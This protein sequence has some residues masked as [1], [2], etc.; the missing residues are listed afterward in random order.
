MNLERI[1]RRAWQAQPPDEHRNTVNLWL[2]V[3]ETHLGEWVVDSVQFSAGGAQSRIAGFR[4]RSRHEAESAFEQARLKHVLAGWVPANQ[5]DPIALA[6]V[7]GSPD[8]SIDHQLRLGPPNVAQVSSSQLRRLRDTPGQLALV[9]KLNGERLLVV[10]GSGVTV[11]GYGDSNTTDFDTLRRAA[12]RSLLDSL[13][14]AEPGDPHL[15]FDALW[16]GG[17]LTLLDLISHDGDL[18]PRPFAMRRA[19]LSQV[20]SEQF[21][22]D[23]G[24]IVWS[25][26]SDGALLADGSAS[27]GM[28]LV[29]AA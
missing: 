3:E 9:D 16:Q 23:A 2:L 14:L 19:L 25:A 21:F 18:R 17:R 15:V 1:V 8:V 10:V 11:L 12:H 6:R 7:G 29:R 5:L 28:G 22:S 27:Y 13:L 4:S 20:F 26:A 24:V